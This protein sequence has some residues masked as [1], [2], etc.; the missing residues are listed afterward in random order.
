VCDITEESTV[1]ALFASGEPD[2]GYI[3]RD[4]LLLDLQHSALVFNPHLD[5]VSNPSSSTH[6]LQMAPFTP[7]SSSTETTASVVADVASDLSAPTPNGKA[8]TNGSSGG[9]PVTTNGKA[10]AEP[11]PAVNGKLSGSTSSKSPWSG[12]TTATDDTKPR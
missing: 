12:V 7:E 10:T 2:E 1:W 8:A 6:H 11:T 5:L 3:K 9:K 4:E